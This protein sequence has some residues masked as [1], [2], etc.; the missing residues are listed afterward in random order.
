MFTD[1]WPKSAFNGFLPAWEGE[2]SLLS[3]GAT[4]SAHPRPQGARSLPARSL[5][6]TRNNADSE[7]RLH[8]DPQVA[9]T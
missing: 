2:M 8:S 5:P 7:K 4:K 3:V 9:Y 1:K 6:I